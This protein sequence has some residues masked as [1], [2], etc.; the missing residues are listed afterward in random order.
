[1][2]VWGALPPA[3]VVVAV[4]DAAG[5]RADALL[6]LLEL[7]AEE[8]HGGLFFGSVDDDVVIVVPASASSI[9]DEFAERFDARLGVSEPTPYAG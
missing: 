7:R 2:D 1:R 9:L 8:R 3:P 5:R 6:D 4:T